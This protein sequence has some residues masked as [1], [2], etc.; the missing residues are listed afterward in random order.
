MEVAGVRPLLAVRSASLFLL[1]LWSI[2]KLGA[3]LATLLRRSM[4]MQSFG[5]KLGMLAQASFPREWRTMFPELV[6]FLLPGPR[7]LY[8]PL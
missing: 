1:S 4:M 2:W 5:A 8:P 7:A 6:F 3:G